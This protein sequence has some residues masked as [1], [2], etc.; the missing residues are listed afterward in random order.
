[1]AGL[2]I[3]PSYPSFTAGSIPF[4]GSDGRPAHDN[5]N[6]FWDNT[7]KRLG[8][9][10]AAS[11]SA[12]LHV[13][14]TTQQARFGYDASN[15]AS[16]TVNSS[17]ALTIASTGTNQNL[18]LTPNG[19]GYVSCGGNGVVSNTVVVTTLK[20]TN[21]QD[22]SINHFDNTKNIYLFNSNSTGKLGFKTTSPSIDFGINGNAAF[23]LGLE[24]HTTANTIGNTLTVQAGGATSGATDKNGGDLILKPGVS[25]GTGLS[26]VQIFGCPAG[27]TGTADGTPAV[28][29]QVLGNKIGLFGVTP[30]VRPTALTTQLTTITFTSPGTPDYAIADL[31]NVGGWAFASQDEG[32]T[33]LS[34][35]ANL[36]V[37][38]LELE[39]KLQALGALT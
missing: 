11:P 35:V 1:M 19:T 20:V 16:L 13:I 10:T 8:L 9:G 36:Q 6:L 21:G 30:V 4:T 25:T 27:S 7:N 28:M 22:L 18:Q 3:T 37:R 38:Q 39:T 33:L 5:T 29:L 23:A 31:I 15:Y 32:R 12:F 26:G 24:R 34:V 17:G 2:Q 14:G